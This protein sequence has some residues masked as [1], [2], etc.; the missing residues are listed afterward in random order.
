MAGRAGRRGLDTV[1]T[2]IIACFGSQPPDQVILRNM[3]TGLSTKL[4]SKFR[5][6][7]TMILNLL[8]VEVSHFVFCLS[9]YCC[10]TCSRDK[11][12]GYVC[13]RYD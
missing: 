13:R 9:L 8:R 3:L 7:Y 11:M 2:V 12:S 4:Q 6:T 5:L 1:G 10:I